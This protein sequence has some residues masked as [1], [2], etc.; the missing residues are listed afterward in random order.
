LEKLR[1]KARLFDEQS[2]SLIGEL[3][4]SKGGSAGT[5][6][7]SKLTVDGIEMDLD[8]VA[9]ICEI[10]LSGSVVHDVKSQNK[11]AGG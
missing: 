7:P 5:D 6:S 11:I 4:E 9:F 2:E 10:Y 8:L 1:V 3:P